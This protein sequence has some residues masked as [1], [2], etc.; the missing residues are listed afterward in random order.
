MELG[1]AVCQAEGA[2]LVSCVDGEVWVCSGDCRGGVE[3]GDC[4][5]VEGGDFLEVESEDCLGV[6]T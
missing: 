3:G 6:E 4:L 5:E 1:E 2:D